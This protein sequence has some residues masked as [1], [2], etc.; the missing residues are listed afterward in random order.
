MNG[1]YNRLL[2]IVGPTLLEERIEEDP[3][4]FLRVLGQAPESNHCQLKEAHNHTTRGGSGHTTKTIIKNV[5]NDMIDQVENNI[6]KEKFGCDIDINDVFECQ[7]R[8]YAGMKHNGPENEIGNEYVA[9]LV[10]LHQKLETINGNNNNSNNNNTNDEILTKNQIP[11]AQALDWLLEKKVL[12]FITNDTELEKT[13]TTTNS[14]Y[15]RFDTQSRLHWG[16]SISH[17]NNNQKITFALLYF[18]EKEKLPKWLTNLKAK[19]KA[20]KKLA[21]MREVSKTKVKKLNFRMKV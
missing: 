16:Q 12:E 19:S 17:L 21:S 10:Q 18:Y 15:I 4:G 13:I 2:H 11:S 5:M 20:V 3:T 6:F 1:Y 8:E 7:L 9:N 14:D